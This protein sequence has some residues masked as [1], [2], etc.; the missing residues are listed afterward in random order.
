MM[1]IELLHSSVS[2]E[3]LQLLTEKS[4]PSSP[5]VSSKL[6]IRLLTIDAH[7]K[8]DTQRRGCWL[9]ITKAPR[10]KYPQM[11]EPVTSQG[12]GPCVCQ[13]SGVPFV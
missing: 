12:E 1:N 13:N 2:S 4:P 3:E 10:G 11:Y 9:A 5:D 8:H 6:P 7:L